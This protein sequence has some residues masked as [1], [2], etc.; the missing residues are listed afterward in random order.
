MPRQFRHSSVWRSLSRAT[1]LRGGNRIPPHFDDVPKLVDQFISVAHENWDV[2]EHPT[3]LAAYVFW[4]LN[5]MHPFIESN[6]RTARA[7]C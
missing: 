7:A 2:A 6:G 5:W 3:M 1:N 4:R